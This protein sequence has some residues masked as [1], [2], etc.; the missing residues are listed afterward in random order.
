MTIQS[1]NPAFFGVC[2]ARRTEEDIIGIST[3]IHIHIHI[4]MYI[5]IYYISIGNTLVYI[6]KPKGWEVMTC[7]RS[8]PAENGQVLNVGDVKCECNK[9]CGFFFFWEVYPDMFNID[10]LL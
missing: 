5:Y 8:K 7:G 1:R 10:F 9:Q 4:H 3:Y 2:K 6:S